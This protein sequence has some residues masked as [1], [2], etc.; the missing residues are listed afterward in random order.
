MVVYGH[1]YCHI[2]KSSDLVTKTDAYD[3]KVEFHVA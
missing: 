1:V 2:Q 3:T